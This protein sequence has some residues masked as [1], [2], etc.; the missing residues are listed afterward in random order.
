MRLRLAAAACAGIV[1][2]G[3]VHA[4]VLPVMLGASVA[5]AW[6]RWRAVTTR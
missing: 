5:Y 2:V 4:P 6:L 3:I 1:L